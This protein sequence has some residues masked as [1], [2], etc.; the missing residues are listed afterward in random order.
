MCCCALCAAA[1]Q[2]GHVLQAAG[3]RCAVLSGGTLNPL[4]EKPETESDGSPGDQNAEDAAGGVKEAAADEVQQQGGDG[5]EPAAKKK[6]KK[7]KGVRVQ[8]PPD[9]QQAADQDGGGDDG[10]EQGGEAQPVPLRGRLQWGAGAGAWW[11]RVL[12]AHDVLVATP[13]ELLQVLVQSLVQVGGVGR[14]GITAVWFCV[15]LLCC[16]A[17][18]VT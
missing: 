7:A 14:F 15:F 2:Q 13:G 3:L 17:R 5:G 18:L 8:L 10:G 11:G 16:F 9:A 4:G 6:K 1:L 12:A